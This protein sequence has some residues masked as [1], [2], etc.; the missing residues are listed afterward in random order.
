MFQGT[1]LARSYETRSRPLSEVSSRR[2]SPSRSCVSIT[3][4]CSFSCS[5]VCFFFFFYRRVRQQLKKNWGRVCVC[6]HVCVCMYVYACMYIYTHIYIYIYVC[7]CV[8]V[9][10]CACYYMGQLKSIPTATPR[11]RRH[12]SGGS[13]VIVIYLLTK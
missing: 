12:S 10:V 8:Y 9:C 6:M 4:S 2:T 5:G 7:V 3:I 1:S 13:D 11:Q